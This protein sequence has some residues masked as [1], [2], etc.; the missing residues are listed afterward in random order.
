LRGA[1]SAHH[2]KA[3]GNKKFGAQRQFEPWPEWMLKK[4]PEAPQP[5]RVAAELIL[6]TGQRPG[7][8]IRMRRDQFHGDWMTVSDEK[9]KKEF[10]TFCPEDLRYF[11]STVPIEGAFIL[12]KN[13]REPLGYDSIE[14]QFRAWRQGLGTNAK[15]FTLHGLRKN[16]IVRLAEAGC[17]DAEIQAVTGQSAEMVAY[18][19]VGASRKALSRAAQLRRD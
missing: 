7:A 12:A 3:T 2:W 6:G 9:G 10:E 1:I 11:L 8:A 13:L 17:S 16:S 19:R 15:P 4:L 5:V 18:Y 14:K